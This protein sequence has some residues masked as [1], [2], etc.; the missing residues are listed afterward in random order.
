MKMDDEDILSLA[1]R[2]KAGRKGGSDV[3]L[4]GLGLGG[5]EYSLGG[6]KG[7][8]SNKLGLSS[9]N[10]FSS[11]LNS[12]LNKIS[13]KP[14]QYPPEAVLRIDNFTSG[15]NTPVPLSRSPT[16]TPMPRRVSIFIF[17]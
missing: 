5:S 12:G 15:T 16:P 13:T 11:S 2:R 6:R 10:S 3:G 7:P 14:R 4:G 1:L 17:N 9:K 8:D